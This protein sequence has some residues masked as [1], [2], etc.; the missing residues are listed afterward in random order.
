[1]K[2]VTIERK[3]LSNVILSGLNEN[4]CLQTLMITYQ[5]KINI[6]EKNIFLTEKNIFLT[7]LCVL[8][9]AFLLAT[10]I[11]HLKNFMELF[12]VDCS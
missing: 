6:I 12:L 5:L 3:K 1:M 8:K 9:Y 4:D 7:F 2:Q 11:I 10:T